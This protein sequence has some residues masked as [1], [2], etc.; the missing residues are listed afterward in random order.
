MEDVIGAGRARQI[1]PNC[2]R[3]VPVIRVQA[4]PAKFLLH[5]QSEVMLA[6][7]FPGKQI[8]MKNVREELDSM[9]EAG[10]RAR[11]IAIGIDREDGT[12]A[13]GWQILPTSW[14]FHL[15]EF[16]GRSMHVVAARHYD[17]HIGT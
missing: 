7:R 11:K 4:C 15:T 13:N 3:Q 2:P 10:T 5:S 16:G 8:R 6:C 1:F 12:V 9:R 17:D 14:D